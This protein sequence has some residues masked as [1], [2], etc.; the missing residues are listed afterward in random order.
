MFYDL[1]VHASTS[2]GENTVEEIAELAKR[3]GIGGIGIV[4]Y[5][6]NSSDLPAVD[7][8]DIVKCTMIKAGNV[9]D[10]NDM[11]AKARNKC[12]VLMVHGGD[13]DINRAACENP[14]V[15][16]LCHPELGRKDSGFDHICAKA[17]NENS[18]A[19]EINFRQILDSYKKNR[20]YVLSAMKK[21]VN[22]YKK[23]NVSVVTASGAVTKWGLRSG[24]ELSAISNLLGLDLG[25]AI[26]TTSLI[27]ETIVSQN[28]EK[29]AGKRWQGAHVVE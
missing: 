24:R 12:E 15:D 4:Q 1:H 19:V 2:V 7:G 22:L 18:V 16:V 10:L 5:Y 26:D 13:Y 9:N 17:A 8:I 3:L 28:R 23:Y 6:P 11:I 29:L 27:P 20:I 14:M 21:N 25:N